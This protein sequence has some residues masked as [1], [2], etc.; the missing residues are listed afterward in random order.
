MATLMIVNSRAD[1]R[2]ELRAGDEAPSG[3]DRNAGGHLASTSSR[4]P[5][6]GCDGEERLAEVDAPVLRDDG[7]REH[8]EDEVPPMIQTGRPSSR[9]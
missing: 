8:L 9:T 3:D 4:S 1:A 5:G 6:T 7:R 2:G